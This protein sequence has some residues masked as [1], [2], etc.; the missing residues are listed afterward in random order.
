[1]CGRFNLYSNIDIL[2]DQFELINGD[3]FE[4][5]PRFNIAPSQDVLAVIEGEDGRRG[6]YLRWGL[7][8]SWANDPKIG[9]K[10]INARAETIHEKPSFKRLLARRRCLVIADGFYEWKKD[11]NKKQP[12]HIFL[13]DKQPFAF[14]GL[15][16]RWIQAGEIIQTC[17]IITTAANEL[18]ADIHDRMPVI[19]TKESERQWLDRK[20]QDEDQLK[21]L[22][23]PYDS[24]AMD[25]YPISEFVNSPRNEGIEILNSL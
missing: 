13:K 12:F 17:T 21:S 10:M 8:P 25:I 1:M 20:I 19:L 14:A 6:G 24:T 22:L 15:W 5:L 2:L 23:I 9:Y 3:M 7:I 4:I 11:G 16:D 18:M